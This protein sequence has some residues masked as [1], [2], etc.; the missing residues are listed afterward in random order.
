MQKRITLACLLLSAIQA[1]GQDNY[2]SQSYAAPLLLNPALTGAFEGRYR[3]SAIYRD[4]WSKPL[5]NPYQ[6]FSTAFDIKWRM[7][8]NTARYKDQAAVG[9]FFYNDKAGALEFS[10]SQISVSAA[11][12]KSLDIRTT[13]YLS[14][15]LQLGIAQKNVNLSNL[16]FQD[17]FNGATGYTNPTNENLPENN[18][19]FADYSVGI[20]YSLSPQ[21]SRLKL[22][23]GAAMHH[24]LS[25]SVSF[26]A[27]SD[28]AGL[29]PENTLH[30]RYS[31]QVS[32]FLPLSDYLALLPRGSYDQQGNHRKI[33]AGSNFRINTSTYKHVALHI[34]G[35]LRLVTDV[36]NASRIDAFVSM[37]G[38][39]FSNILIG[40][41][42][43]LNFDKT[44]RS[45]RR[46][47]ELSITYL[48]EYEDDIVLCPKF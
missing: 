7:G 11:F 34:G 1:I 31:A 6:T 42:Y 16:S 17:Q 37:L 18:F 27:R 4:Q 23:V 48:G 40:M 38:V 19:A 5:D 8:H 24:F 30:R 47:F 36:D 39:E 3:V 35:Y 20:N 14:L 25:P 45:D 44:A 28:E 46:S 10:T 33:D 9:L 13:Q 43:D 22:F 41:S 15:G 21:Y 26:F 32:S 12:H 2:F 29:Q